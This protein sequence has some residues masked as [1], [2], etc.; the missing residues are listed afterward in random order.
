MKKIISILLVGLFFVSCTK[1]VKNNDD[2][3]VSRVKSV[4]LNQFAVIK[5]LAEGNYLSNI[6]YKEIKQAGNFG[7]G[8]FNYLNGEMVALNGKFYQ[9]KVD[10]S[11]NLVKDSD[12]APF[13][14]V[15]HFI[16][17]QSF[18]VDNKIIN[19][20][21]LQ[22]YLGNYLS[23]NK[24]IYSFKIHSEFD[25]LIVRSVPAQSLPFPPL[26]EVINNQT[27]FHLKNIKGTLVGYWFPQYLSNVNAPG[28]HFHF[29]SD[30]EKHAGHVI[31]C[32]FSKADIELDE[33]TKLNIVIPQNE[34]YQSN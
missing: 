7:L 28:F 26:T 33:L 2:S 8:T 20:T 1:E 29:I 17:D 24:N 21:E 10:G 4:T 27:L 13:A 34:E 5:T 3:K 23:N 31:S 11:V 18:K 9:A 19:L 12:C 16:A 25:S 32:S 15:H 6:T 14:A 22:N 30:D